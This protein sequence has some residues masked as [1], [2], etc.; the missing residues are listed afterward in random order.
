MW[1]LQVFIE[2]IVKLDTLQ[3]YKY[4]RSNFVVGVLSSLLLAEALSKV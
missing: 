2:D 3:L 1:F 4:K